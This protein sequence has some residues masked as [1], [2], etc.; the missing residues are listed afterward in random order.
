MMKKPEQRRGRTA[1]QRR[2]T[3]PK[4]FAG[5]PEPTLSGLS[6]EGWKRIAFEAEVLDGLIAGKRT[7]KAAVLAG[8]VL[9]WSP[10]KVYAMCKAY[11]AAGHA[12][13]L[14][15]TRSGRCWRSALTPEQDAIIEAQLKSFLKNQR[16]KLISVYVATTVAAFEAANVT[17]PS[18]KSIRRR[19]EQLPERVRYAHKHG[20]RAAADRFDLAQGSTPPTYFPLERVQ[21]DHTPGDLWCMSE[22]YTLSLGRPTVTLV[23]DEFSRLV[24][25]IHVT[26]GHPSIEELAE[27]MAIA[28]LPKDGW[29]K[30][31]G[32]TGIEWP[33]FGIPANIFVDRGV[34]FT[35]TAFHRGCQKWRIGLSHRAQPHHGGIVERVIRTAMEE[36]KN[37]PGNTRF[38]K[39]QRKEDRIDPAATSK[40]TLK[41]YLAEL[42]RYFVVE[43]PHRIHPALG[44]TPAEKWNLGIHQFGDPRR[45]EDPQSFYLDFLKGDSRKLEKYG[46][47]VSYL[48]YRDRQLQP[49]LNHAK[50]VEVWVKRD[51]ADVSR[52]F[53][54][55]PR[56]GGYIELSNDL[57]RGE[58][59]T[60]AEWEKARKDLKVKLNGQPVTA[61]GILGFINKGR[62]AVVR[63]LSPKQQESKLNRAKRRKLECNVHRK[64]RSQQRLPQQPTDQPI[65]PSR[66]MI[67]PI[68]IP[69]FATSGDL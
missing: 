24:I 48:D 4:T 54:E 43:Y 38:S 59:I 61:S 19:F 41:E 63:T 7:R 60:V 55:D 27:A 18:K 53:V 8:T 14:A 58:G 44:M 2:L 12:L 37:L 50:K 17:A 3:T 31:M 13:A 62:K 69:I 25:G 21:L 33:W 32:I 52:A 46:V 57:T 28:C 26:F 49:L 47:K 34:D 15:K 1:A 29:L 22:D 56:G 68:N 9:G 6:E 30:A 35:S 42:V 5:L 65:A 67:D 36:T 20:A 51:P 10:S 39:A 40:L 23:I 45:V 66:F 16:G 11:R 64:D